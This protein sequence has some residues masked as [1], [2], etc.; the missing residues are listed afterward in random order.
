MNT[1]WKSAILALA[2][3]TAAANATTYALY[4]DVG[5]GTITGSYPSFTLTGANGIG[6]RVSLTSYTG[7]IDSEQLLTFNYTYTSYDEDGADF[8]PAGY[9]LNGQMY[10][11]SPNGIYGPIT[12]NGT[13]SLSL[14]SGDNFGWYVRSMDS[15][16]GP[17]TLAIS[18]SAVP[19]SE[20]YAMLL[21]GLGLVG[22]ASR[23]KRTAV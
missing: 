5:N 19:E 10:Q 14:H 16:L 6:A 4:N 18:V 11:L 17:A 13:V 3:S 8:D 12:I 1:I 9:M 22:V 15:L 2:F 21:A 7:V 20:T 23:R